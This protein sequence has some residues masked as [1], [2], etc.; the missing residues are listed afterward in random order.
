MRKV[1]VYAATFVLMVLIGQYLVHGSK[2]GKVAFMSG[3]SLVLTL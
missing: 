1:N 2:R 3:A